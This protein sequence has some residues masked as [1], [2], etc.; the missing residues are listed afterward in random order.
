V[1]Q[2]VAVCVR[3]ERDFAS[4]ATSLGAISRVAVCCSVV[5]CVAGCCSVLPSPSETLLLPQPCGG[6][7]SYNRYTLGARD[8]GYTL[9]AR[10][11]EI[12]RDREKI[13]E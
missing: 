10:E 1:V 9:G 11:R 8:N 13:I 6:G 5:Q 2:C 4:A 3:D 7:A 12:Q